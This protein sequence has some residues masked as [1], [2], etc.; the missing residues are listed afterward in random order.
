MIRRLSGCARGAA[1]LEFALV[2]PA[3]IGMIVLILEGGRMIWTQQVLQET[4]F[5]AARCLGVGGPGCTEAA[6]PG[7]ARDQAGQSGLRIAAATVTAT[8]SAAPALCDNRA[9][10]SRIGIASPYAGAVGR[11][12]PR[13]RTM[14][15]ASACFPKLG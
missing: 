15:Y 7:W 6:M 1:A 4:A 5:N 3:L 12:L 8:A 2:A 14:L 13:A 10:M 9:G 11:L